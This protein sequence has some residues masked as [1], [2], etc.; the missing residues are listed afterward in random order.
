MCVC[1]C[2]N[3]YAPTGAKASTIYVANFT[4]P[5]T[6]LNTVKAIKSAVYGEYQPCVLLYTWRTSQSNH[7]IKRQSN[8]GSNQ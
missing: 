4:N 8:K 1:V 7:D 6:I 2:V 5:G 3:D